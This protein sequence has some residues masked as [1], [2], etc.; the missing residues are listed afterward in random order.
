MF[1]IDIHAPHMNIFS[2]RDGVEVAGWSVDPKTWVRF[3]A[4]P[5]RVWA[6]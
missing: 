6:L 5:H 2:C 4:Y 3:L 1:Q